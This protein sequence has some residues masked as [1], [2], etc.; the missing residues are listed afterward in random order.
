MKKFLAI[1]LT[2]AMLVTCVPAVFAEDAL[3]AAAVVTVDYHTNEIS[4]EYTNPAAYKCHVNIYMVKEADAK[5]AIFT[6]Y[7]KA[8]RIGSVVADGNSTATVVFTLGMDIKDDKYYFYAAPGGTD[9]AHNYVKSE[10]K[11]I[12]SL[13][14]INNDILPAIN[15]GSIENTAY[16]ANNK[17]KD[18]FDFGAYE[19][20]KD[21]YLYTMKIKDFGGAYANVSQVNDAWNAADLIYNVKA[22]TVTDD[23]DDSDVKMLAAEVAALAQILGVDTQNAD[24]VNYNDAFNT[25]Y[26][27]KL[28]SVVTKSDAAQLFGEVAALTAINERDTDSKANVFEDYQT[29]LGI[30]DTYLATIKSK[31]TTVVARNMEGFTATTAEAAFLKIQQVVNSIG[32]PQN[33]GSNAGNGGGGGGGG[34][35]IDPSL[36]QQLNP[37]VSLYT[38]TDVGASHWALKA[39][40]YLADKGVLSGNGDGTFAPDKTVTREEFVKMIIAAFSFEDTGLSLSFADVANSHW[41][42]KYIRAAVE[43]GIVKGV[44]DTRFGMGSYITR[45]D[46][47]VIANRIIELKGINIAAGTAQF[48]DDAKISDYAKDAVNILAGAGILNGYQDGSFKPQGSLTRAEAAKVIYE[49]VNR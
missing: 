46:M 41:A 27:S 7:A 17:L 25:M 14:T 13:D 28:A 5:S 43:N 4:V 11:N 2:L 6:D 33:Y 29:E 1:L 10:Y 36:E 20:W 40:E 32:A 26:Q 31:G 12:V 44:S 23:D 38:F 21:E 8:V 24:Y 22:V 35:A 3:Q 47:A 49:L 30:T 9:S 18:V 37:N 45:Q 16:I 19:S 42:Y 34:L 39:V 15:K 48:A